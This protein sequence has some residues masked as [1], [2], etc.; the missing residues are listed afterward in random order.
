MTSSTRCRHA[1]S[2]AFSSSSSSLNQRWYAPSSPPGTLLRWL[3]RGG[4][5]ARLLSAS[6]APS[7]YDGRRR[8]TSRQIC[9]STASVPDDST[10]ALR[11]TL[12]MVAICRF[13]TVAD[14]HFL[15]T[16]AGRA[17]CFSVI[18]RS[19]CNR[20]LIKR[21]LCAS[22]SRTHDILCFVESTSSVWQRLPTRRWAET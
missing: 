20:T 4:S 8:G 18:W 17:R 11:R 7:V 6:P 10:A 12:E 21:R 15:S 19:C 9:R 16:G 13:V 14:G 22:A 3:N 1:S 5:V 2:F